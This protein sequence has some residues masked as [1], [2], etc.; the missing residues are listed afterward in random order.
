MKKMLYLLAAPML[1]ASC[2]VHEFPELPEKEP[3]H[4]RLNYETDMTI[5]EHVYDGTTL[6]EVG[7]GATYDNTQEYGS[8]RSIVRIYPSTEAMRSTRSH[9]EELVVNRNIRDGYDQEVTV[10]MPG[11]EYNVMVWSDITQLSTQRPYYNA[12]DFFE[13]MLQGDHI[14]NTDYRDAFRGKREYNFVVDVVQSDPDTLNITMQRPLAKFEI[15]SNDLKAFLDKEYKA[16]LEEAQS[17]GETPES[18]VKAEDYK[19]MIFYSGYMPSAFNINTDKPVDS[20]LGVAFESQ[21]NVLNDD[22]ASI[23]F[24]YVFVNGTNS[25][26]VVQVGIYNKEGKQIALSNPITVPLR[27]SRHT[28]MRGSFLLQQASGGI[29]IIPEFNG[30]HNIVIQ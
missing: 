14:G 26:V 24:D 29:V 22:E 17:R 8:M 30:N 13:V 2:D 18:R 1:L 21:I 20:L 15:I 3:F 11:G 5:W 23:G 6:K 19:V 10:E 4:L 27:R 7:F 25:A 16:M 9:L 12:D 28:I